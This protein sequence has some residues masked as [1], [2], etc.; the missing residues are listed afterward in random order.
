MT[1]RLEKNINIYVLDIIRLGFLY[2]L[3]LNLSIGTPLLRGVFTHKKKME[4]EQIINKIVEE[5]DKR[6]AQNLIDTCEADLADYYYWEYKQSEWN[7]EGFARMVK[8]LTGSAQEH[9][10]EVKKFV[11][12]QDD[13]IKGWE[14]KYN[15]HLKIFAD[16]A[17]DSF[18]IVEDIVR[19]EML[20]NLKEQYGIS[21]T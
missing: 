20:L 7:R 4:T 8:N 1:T 18:I 19:E 5:F 6:S 17:V 16:M 14:I 21:N 15:D 3:R 11:A 9:F 10:D 12:E 13:T 2:S